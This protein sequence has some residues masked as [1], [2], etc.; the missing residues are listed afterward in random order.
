M[1]FASGSGSE[2]F[3]ASR[4]GSA[5][6]RRWN[7]WPRFRVDRWRLS[8]IQIKPEPQCV[9]VFPSD[10]IEPDPDWPETPEELQAKYDMIHS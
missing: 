10:C 8:L 3:A 6:R 2:R 4:P 5:C 7:C 1:S 9:L